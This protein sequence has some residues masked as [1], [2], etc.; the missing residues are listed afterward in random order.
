MV[1]PPG[2]VFVF[3]EIHRLALHQAIEIGSAPW[4]RYASVQYAVC[5]IRERFSD[6]VADRATPVGAHTRQP[7]LKTR[8][9]APTQDMEMVFCGFVNGFDGLAHV[10]HFVVKRRNLSPH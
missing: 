4:E 9:H 8:N 1:S 7:G 6:Q 2:L 3:Q 5:N 10:F